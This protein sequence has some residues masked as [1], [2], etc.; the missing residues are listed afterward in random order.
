MASAQNYVE[1]PILFIFCT[2]H[3]DVVGVVFSLSVAVV[4]VRRTDVLVKSS[5]ECGA[6]KKAAQLTNQFAGAIDGAGCVVSV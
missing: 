4:S 2:E 5:I 3:F 6:Q 1:Q